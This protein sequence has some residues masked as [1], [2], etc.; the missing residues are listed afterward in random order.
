MNPQIALILGQDGVANGAIYALLA[1]SILLVFS[2]TRALFIPQGEFVVYG[3]LCMAAM[4]AGKPVALVW[5]LAAFA[6]AAGI[7]D[8]W[9]R[10]ERGE[11]PVTSALVL[12][13]AYPFIL[14]FLLYRLPL[15]TLPMW[16]QALLTLALVVPMGPQMYRLF[17][18][19]IAGASTLVLLIVSISVH[20]AL[21]GLGLLAFG[22][23][24]ARSAPFDDSRFTLGPVSV[25]SQT[26]WIVAVSAMLIVGLYRFFGHTVYGKALRATAQN[27]EGARLV[28]ISPALAG[29]AVFFL[30]ALIGASSGILVGPATTLYYD[31]GFLISLKG[32]VG[33]I[34]GGLASYPVAALGALCVG[35]LEAFSSFWASAYKEIIVFTLIIP[36]LLWRSLQAQPVEEEEE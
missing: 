17:Y 31:S 25:A 23:D 12:K 4:Q 32:F 16:M 30:A 8:M 34:I 9:S 6:V 22:P 33:A 35:L 2:V 29:K 14:A 13:T 10:V 3:A 19:P 20:L 24:G 21:V 1:L 28:G 26:L 36:V 27:R 18:Q 7:A 15:A 11:A 5:L